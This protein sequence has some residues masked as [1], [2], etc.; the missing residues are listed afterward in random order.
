M[1][2]DKYIS[3]VTD[4]SRKQ[5]KRALKSAEFT[6]NGVVVTDPTFSVQAEDEVV[7]EGELL[8]EAKPRYFMLNKPEG[9]VCASKDKLNMTVMELLDEDNID[10]LHVAGRLDI[11]TTGLVLIT[12]DGQW[13]H[14]V[15]SPRS[16]CKKTYYIETVD[17]ITEETAEAFRQG[18][19][20][21]GELKATL[22]AELEQIHE[23][24]ARLTIS[25]GKYHQVKRMF[26]YMGNK[27]ELLH[28]EAIGEIVLDDGLEP[29]EYRELTE[30]E[31]LSVMGKP[32]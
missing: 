19:K 24:A 23:Q 11:D 10:Q 30:Q 12:D 2:L 31:V 21:K 15:T 13:S 28:R 32:S 22:P 5:V 26:A 8:R 29:G 16:D 17:P 1:R 14:Q 7:F 9:Y 6:V 27:V 18:I 20:L 4:L 25:E 3:S